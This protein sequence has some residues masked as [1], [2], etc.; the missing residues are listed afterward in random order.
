MI[1]NKYID[2]WIYL[3]NGNHIEHC[4]DQELLLDNNIIPVLERKDVTVDS[5]RIERGLSL[6]KYFPFELLPWEL[7]QFAVIAGVFIEEDGEQ[8][9]YFNEIRDI[10]GRGSGKNGFIDFLAFYFISPLHGVHGYNVDLIANG[11]DQAATSIQDVYNIVNDPEPKNARAIKANF[12]ATKEKITGLKMNAEFRL[13]TTS[14]KNKDSKRTGCVIFDEK[15]QYTDTRNANTLTSG[16]GKMKWGRIITITTDGHERGGVLDTEKRQNEEI[17][18]EYNPANRVMVNWFRIEDE[19][20]W[21]QIDKVVK[22]NPSI[23]Y[24]SFRSIKKR[25]ESEI[26]NM[27]NTPEYYPEFLAKRCNFPVSDPEKAVAE[28]SDIEACCREPDF[29]IEDGM[30]C[31]GGLDYSK[32]NDFI[33]CI[34]VFRK[35]DQF[36]VIHHS[37][38]CKASKDLPS[39]KAPVMEW[40]KQGICTIVDDVEVP[41]DMVASWFIQY[42]GKY[43]IRMIG[44]DS[45]RFSL[46]SNAFKQY[47]FEC[48]TKDKDKKNMWLTRR[49]DI[50]KAAPIINSLFINRRISGFDRMMCWY[51]NNA[52]QIIESNGNITY[53]KIEPKLRKTDG[54]MAFVHAMCCVEYLPDG[55]DLPDIELGAFVYS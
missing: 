48:L 36:H 16:L 35:G 46:L 5:E 37:F 39:I 17:L 25:I 30:T 45:F 6:M 38:I 23:V 29:E 55:A 51:V 41:A 21:N 12:R 9:I 50:I 8:D 2:E 7:F 54:F 53:G 1:Y 24:P 44:I 19:K 13:N 40:A 4:K 32:T 15:H 52:K 42:V 47:G 22:A 20:E 49:S 31:I 34:L 14:T 11:E 18:R 28:W 43:Y 33:G 27:S 3:I 10:L 26:Q